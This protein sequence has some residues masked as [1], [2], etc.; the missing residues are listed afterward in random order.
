M[1]GKSCF[2]LIRRS[3]LIISF[4]C[5][6]LFF[7]C[8]CF[9][10]SSNSQSA[11]SEEQ[12]VAP[13]EVPLYN[14][15]E[16]TESTPLLNPDGTLAAWGW[17]RH[18][19]LEYDRD[20]IQQSQADRLK[21]WDFFSISSPDCYMEIT[22]ADITWAVLVSVSLVDYQTGQTTSN[23]RFLLNSDLLNLPP[24]PYGSTL[25]DR[26]GVH[27]SFAFEDAIRTL[28]FDFARSL[29]FGPPISGEVEILDDPQD[30]SLVT[31]MPFYQPDIF[32]YTNKI[33][34][35]P[36]CGSVE[37]DGRVYTF[38]QGESYAVLDWGRGVWPEEFVWG[39]AVAAGEVDG[40][41]LGFNIGFGDEDNSR[42]SGNSVVYDGVLH[43]LGEID[44]TYDPQDIMQPWHFKSLDGRFD[45]V[46]EPFFDQSNKIDL[47]IYFMDTIKV[48]GN[49]SGHVVLDDGP[50]VEI[51][52]FLGFAEHAFQKW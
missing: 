19:L 20:F 50:V 17:A 40:K 16:I 30:E 49:V 42:A 47:I 31:A 2:H 37:A 33:V 39:W 46:L 25:F 14:D 36:A 43:K 11:I 23:L 35:L 21:E 5:V 1:I 24:E 3:G 28:S 10:D 26:W 51:H 52:N 44:W 45:M 34:A 6:L 4:F 15:W 22:L 18:A 9:G 29:L 38:P 12:P 27:V 32:F 13:N 41:R 48:H 7:L 8:G